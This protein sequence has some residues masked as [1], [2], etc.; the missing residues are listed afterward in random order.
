[1]I[2]ATLLLAGCD[3]PEH[4]WTRAKAVNTM[5]AYRSFVDA[6]PESDHAENAR[7]RLRALQD[8]FDW[9]SAQWTNTDGA[10]KNYLQ[11][12]PGGRHVQEAQAQVF[13]IER[14]RAW[15]LVLRS[16]SVDTLQ[17]YLRTYPYASN[18]DEAR[19]QLDALT[20]VQLAEAR[21]KRSGEKKRD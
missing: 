10:F 5:A 1:M 21:S 6:H 19:R 14:T 18:A 20:F 15:S 11:S 17:G 13:E 16:P 4:D 8:E 9:A 3:T 12:D 7:A 2:L